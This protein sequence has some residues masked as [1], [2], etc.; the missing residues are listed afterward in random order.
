[1]FFIEFFFQA[2]AI[3]INFGCVI[4]IPVHRNSLVLHNFWQLIPKRK[5]FPYH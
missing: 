2:T 4:L 1:M 3:L 5:W